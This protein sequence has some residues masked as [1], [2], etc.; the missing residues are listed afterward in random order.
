MRAAG[1][2]GNKHR[3]EPIVRGCGLD[4]ASAPGINSSGPGD[5]VDKGFCGN[6]L[7][8][9]AI[10]HVEESVLRRL[11]DDLTRG[12]RDVQ[13]GEHEWLRRIIVPV[14]LRGHLVVPNQ[15]PVAGRKARME[16][17]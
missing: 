8:G 6:K 16:A 5:S 2:R 4:R 17:R 7:A 1:R 9:L 14:F 13:V 12:A 11:H 3:V 10:E 15:L